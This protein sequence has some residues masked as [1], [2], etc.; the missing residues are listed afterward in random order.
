M[1]SRGWI[2]AV[3]GM[4][5]FGL[6]ACS[7]N[8]DEASAVAAENLVIPV[9]E[10]PYRVVEVLSDGWVEGTVRVLGEVPADPV[11]RVTMDQSVCGAELTDNA[12]VTREGRL[13]GVV[14]WLSD[15]REGR[16]LPAARRHEVMS[17]KC[18]LEPRVQAV[19]AGGTLNFRN[20]DPV[21]QR[22][23]VRRYRDGQALALIEQTGSGQVVP[24]D[25]VLSRPGILE[26]TSELRPWM[27]GWVAV[28]D[29]PYFAVTDASGA[30][31]L[32]GIPPGSYTLTAW[33]ER[34]GRAEQR[35]DVVA[36]EPTEVELT[37]G[38]PVEELDEAPGVE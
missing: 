4:L 15:I 25:R 9:A 35:V 18:R 20:S 19:A 1:V 29:H 7:A 33:H 37:F 32:E 13:R 11:V 16:A 14:V 34:L 8:E 17:E 10:E 5:S 36:G 12:V 23:V 21:P 6:A 22:T 30:F 38:E 26:L 27:R 31:A 24:D 28:F 3:C 2:F